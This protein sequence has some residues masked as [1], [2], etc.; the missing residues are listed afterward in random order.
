MSTERERVAAFVS[1]WKA[2]MGTDSII[3]VRG[4]DGSIY[5]LWVTDLEAVLNDAS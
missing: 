2:S 4:F 1:E 5:R 3:S